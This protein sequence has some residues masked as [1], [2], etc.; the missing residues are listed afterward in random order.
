MTDDIF[1]ENILDHFR[2]PRNKGTIAN[3]DIEFQDHNPLC[4][5]EV[6]IYLKLDENQTIVDIKTESKGCAISQ[7][8][9]SMLTDALKGKTIEEI[10]QMKNKFVFDLLQIQLS[11]IRVK[12]ALLA[13]KAMQKG[14]YKYLGATMTDDE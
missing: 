14:I 10:R 13:L 12:C 5:D 8:V 1:R 7:A 9:A 6:H 2:D 3:A 4:G 11:P